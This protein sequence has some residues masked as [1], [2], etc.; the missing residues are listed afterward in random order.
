MKTL[1]RISAMAAVTMLLAVGVHAQCNDA[2]LRGDYIFTVSGQILD[3][4]P[5]NGVAKT[6]FDGMGNLKQV[7][8]VVHNGTV[9]PAWRPGQGTY[10][11]SSDCTGSATI[12]PSTGPAI[13]LEFVVLKNGCEIRTVV[14][15]ANYQIN[16]IGVRACSEED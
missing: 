3:V 5:V 10:S 15:D 16:S 14:S 2:T 6:H 9:P 8:F 12:T 11:I 1:C 4:G 13:D 7:D